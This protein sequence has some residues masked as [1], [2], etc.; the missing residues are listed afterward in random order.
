MRTIIQ[1]LSIIALSL[2]SLSANAY[3]FMVDSIAYEINSDGNT[4]S[5]TNYSNN[6]EKPHGSVVIPSTV[7]YNGKTYTVTVIG[8]SSFDLCNR[9]TS[10][11][12]PNTVTSINDYAFKYCS[13]LIQ[14][15]IP[16]SVKSI[17]E[18]A[19]DKCKSLNQI[20]IPN[21][22][23]SI[24]EYAFRECKNL[25]SIDL[26]NS[27]TTI[28]E[29]TFYE[30]AGL[31]SVTIPNTVTNIDI[32]A[33]YGCT[34]LTSITLSNSLKTL[35]G[36]SGC[37]GLTSVN[38]PNSVTT[39]DWAAFSG[40]TGL[41]SVS[42]PNSVT[43]INQNAFN[44]CIGLTS[45]TI[46][47]SVKILGGF[48][49]CTGLTSITI[50]NSVTTISGDAFNGC[51]G[52]TSIDIPNSIKTL[53]GFSNCTGLTSI[54]IPNSV[55]TISGDAFKGC[56]GLTSITIPNSVKT[57]SGFRGCT[58]LT[59]I[60]IPNS[61][62]TIDGNAFRDCTSLISVII[63]NSVT[64]IKV[65]AF[66]GCTALKNIEIPNSLTEIESKVFAYSGL[67]T[68]FIPASVVS[69]KSDSFIGNILSC[70]EVDPSNPVYDSRNSCNAVIETSTNNLILGCQK[71][72]IPS[73]VKTIGTQAFCEQVVLNS[74]DIPNTITKIDSYAF[75]GC[76]GLD[77]LLIGNS[78]TEIEHYAF[79][80]CTGLNS[81]EI[82]NSV[83]KISYRAFKDCSQ[84]DSLSIGESV[85]YIG[86]EAFQ[87][88]CN[89][90]S[91]Q[92]KSIITPR[93]W[94]ST[95]DGVDK[96][97]KVYVPSI[98]IDNYRKA[99]P[100]CAFNI[101]ADDI[102]GD[103][104]NDDEVNIADINSVIDAILNGDNNGFVDVNNDNEV[105]I[106]DVNSII[107]M[108]LG[109]TPP[110]SALVDEWFTV[111]GV[112]FR[113]IKV[114]GG[115]FTMGAT[116]EQESDA[117]IDEN[118]AHQVPLSDYYI[119]ETEVTQKLWKAV[120]GNNPS[121]NK[122]SADCPVEN[123]PYGDTGEFLDRLYWLT[124]KS[125]RLPTEAE[126][127]YAARGGNR[128]KGYKYAGSNNIDE[129]ANYH[130]DNDAKTLGVAS[131][132]PNEL[133]IYDMSGNVYEPCRDNYSSNYYSESPTIN[134]TGPKEWEGDILPRVYRGGC[135]QDSAR[136]CRVS[137]RDS[138]PKTT[139]TRYFGLRLVM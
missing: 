131:K 12:I 44:R 2:C 43:T 57:L 78:V 22:V 75:E 77:S 137:N 104:N 54:T 111:N 14:V 31:T 55:T 47:N 70:I 30:C 114:I 96:N 126:W 69:I 109:G 135:F 53:S 83:K 64:K 79:E 99:E 38:I 41:T 97:I 95:F 115:T 28:C 4:V 48:S 74:I 68:L 50:P 127:E 32:D 93:S 130:I 45:I 118:A 26:P 94:A 56:T 105:N 40:C 13:S 27:L 123:I 59:S 133:G 88:C 62:T 129:V 138:W 39:I 63:P 110:T 89:L 36:F 82:P 46:P 24:G 80:G 73:T 61:V 9:I 16:N 35:S 112:T 19:F 122:Y 18:Y 84:L 124:G 25:N 121:F 29:G 34:G 67:D 7:M 107:N 103:V 113:M 33:F 10:V 11:N 1:L 136:P 15:S 100:W 37:T 23:K 120:M 52:L 90:N 116:S 98:S 139:V 101:I 58:G 51:T 21:S 132:A 5:T 49:G 125:F 20:N 65:D 85:W 76:T 102:Y 119:S 6:N 17:G 42:I 3:D 66:Y 86:V 8:R 72:V 106:A 87:N 134:P 71:T 81:I 60:T 92:L 117:E 128:S 91:I 108:I